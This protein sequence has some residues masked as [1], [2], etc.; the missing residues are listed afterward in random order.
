MVRMLSFIMCLMLLTACG[1]EKPTGP[2][3]DFITINS[4]V[5]AAGTTLVAGERVTFTAVLTCTIVSDSGGFT[6]LV[7]QDQR[8]LSLL[9][10]NEQPP[11][12]ALRKGTNTVTLSQTITIPQSGS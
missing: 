5:P 12:A 4:I 2:T 8:N 6:T 7:V 10:F 11:E 1:S 3:T 9:E